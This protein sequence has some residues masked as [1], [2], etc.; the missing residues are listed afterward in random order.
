MSRDKGEPVHSFCATGAF[1]AYAH[2]LLV[3]MADAALKASTRV[4]EHTKLALQDY[5]SVPK[6]DEHTTKT[7]QLYSFLLHGPHI[8]SRWTYELPPPSN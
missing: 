7:H 6:I 8:T 4:S 1:D 3:D 5:A 2:Q